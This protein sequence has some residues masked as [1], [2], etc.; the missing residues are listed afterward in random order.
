ML[1]KTLLISA[2]AALAA[3]VACDTQVDT[4]S[5]T[6]KYSLNAILPGQ[7]ASGMKPL[8]VREDSIVY[9]LTQGYSYF[10]LDA[11]GDNLVNVESPGQGPRELYAAD[12]GELVVNEHPAQVGKGYNGGWEFKGDGS[13][14]DVTYYGANEWYSCTSKDDPLHGGQVVHIKKGDKYACENPIKLTIVAAK[15]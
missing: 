13:V 14:Q 12:D 9:G 3:P 8:Q 10:K 5:N 4:Q 2:T 15:D 1:F 11:V 6:Q 7:G